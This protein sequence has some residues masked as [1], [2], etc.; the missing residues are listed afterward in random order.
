[1]KIK[2]YI[3]GL[4]LLSA[5]SLAAEVITLRS[6]QTIT[7]QIILQ[8]EEVVLIR[9]SRGTRFQYPMSDILSI[10]SGDS[11]GKSGANTA[12]DTADIG[13]TEGGKKAMLAI[14]LSG[15]ALAIAKGQW[16]GYAAGELFV[17]SRQIRKKDIHVGGSVG[18]M[19][20]FAGKQPY[21][22]LPICVSA[23]MALLPGKHS[24]LVGASIG[25][26]VALSKLYLGGLHTC[27]DLAYR[28]QINARASVE[29]GVNVRFQQATLPLTDTVE[30]TEYTNPTAGRN[31]VAIG[32]KLGLNF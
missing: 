11:S 5:T 9:D 1:M 18:Y 12:D 26:G 15:G 13:T 20:V 8:N 32:L 16:G 25:Y 29:T 3:L 14:D 27:I 24:P 22:F 31:M 28:Y 4:L 6:G 2:I 7:G 19:G 21:H 23:R 10:S 30:S 17:G